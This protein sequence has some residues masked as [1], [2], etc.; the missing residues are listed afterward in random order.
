MFGLGADRDVRRPTEPATSRR[1][2][3]PCSVRTTPISGGD[4]EHFVDHPEL[5]AFDAVLAD[6]VLNAPHLAGVLSADAAFGTV[7]GLT[8]FDPRRPT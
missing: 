6:A 3:R 2:S 4:L 7:R 5:G 8:H 1:C